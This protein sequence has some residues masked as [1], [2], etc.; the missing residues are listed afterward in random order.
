MKV[1]I[2]DKFP[3]NKQLFELASSK[4][5]EGMRD[6]FLV[7]LQDHKFILYKRKVVGYL[8]TVAYL[9]KIKEAIRNAINS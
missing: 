6:L 7:H 8:K 1:Q 4:R 5:S 2:N 3:V 9:Q